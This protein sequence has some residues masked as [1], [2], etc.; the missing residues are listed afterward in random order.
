MDNIETLFNTL[1]PDKVPFRERKSP[2]EKI[3]TPSK[4]AKEMVDSLPDEVW[5]SRTTFLDPTCKSGI[6]LYE[7]YKKLM[8]SE[9]VIKEYPD[10]KE[11]HFHIINNQLYGIALDETCRFISMRTVYGQI[12]ENSNIIV[13]NNY[14]RLVKEQDSERILKDI[15]EKFGAMKF[16]VVIGNPPYQEET[17]GGRCGGKPLYQ[18]FVKMAFDISARYS[19]MIIPAKWYIS[20]KDT[21]DFTKWMLNNNHIRM[22]SDFNN[23]D[24]VFNKITMN[25]GVCFYLMDKQ[26]E[27][28]CQIANCTVK[29]G[30]VI[31]LSQDNRQLCTYEIINQTKDTMVFIRDNVVLGIIKKIH[32]N[33]NNVYMDSICSNVSPF[34]IK[35]T[36]ND[37]WIKRTD[38]QIKIIK[39]YDDYG[40]IE[41]SEVSKGLDMI[42]KY[43][44]IVGTLNGEGIACLAK[45]KAVAVIT[46]PKILNPQEVCTLTYLVV[47]SFDSLEEASNFKSYL[48]TKTIRLLINSLISSAYITNRAFAFV[49]IPDCSHP[50]T[51]E[52]LYKKYNLTEDEISYIEKTIKPMT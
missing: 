19:T 22:L 26:F 35:T 48:E 15:G 43:N 5:N 44:V 52:M 49:P 47:N 13:I 30:K 42:D 27:G 46:R 11:R 20:N 2:D 25:S 29:E 40:F 39:S 21:K 36:V 50:W 14:L 3:L 31:R 9:E 17:G 38:T 45:K 33:G 34:G 1:L 12:R 51:D 16:D 23:T 28:N 6:F 4:I 41:R 8:E 10:R 32:S 37:D 7:I 18:E 24:D